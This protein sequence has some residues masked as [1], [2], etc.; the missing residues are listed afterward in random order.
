MSA[1]EHERLL[2]A[3]KAH[4]SCAD[5]KFWAHDSPDQIVGACVSPGTRAGLAALIVPLDFTCD[6]FEAGV[7]DD[8]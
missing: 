5:C 8:E 3:W 6:E 1:E 2:T 4:R 7:Y